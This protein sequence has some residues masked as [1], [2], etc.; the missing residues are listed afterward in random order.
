MS[1]VAEAMVGT[2]LVSHLT[3]PRGTVRCSDQMAR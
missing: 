2:G 1:G 3:V